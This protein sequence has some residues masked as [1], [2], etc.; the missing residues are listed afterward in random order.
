MA[1]RCGL[2]INDEEAAVSQESACEVSN[3]EQ[4]GD[5]DLVMLDAQDIAALVV[6]NSTLNV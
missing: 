1:E 3:A 6:S 4:K 2:N 5:S